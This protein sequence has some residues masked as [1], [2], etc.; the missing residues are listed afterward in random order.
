MDL[1]KLLTKEKLQAIFNQFDID[2]S[3]KI[4]F[5]DIKVAFTKFG[6]DLPDDEVHKIL[7]QHDADQNEEIDLEE[8]KSMMLAITGSH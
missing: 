1:E 5:Q 3:G 4:N 7:K 2:H 8:F 6:R